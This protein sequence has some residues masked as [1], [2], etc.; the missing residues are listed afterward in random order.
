MSGFTPKT[1]RPSTRIPRG[2][3]SRLRRVRTS[4]P[5]PTSS[6]THSAI[7][8]AT[9]ILPVRDLP[10]SVFEVAADVFSASAG[11][12]ESATRSGARPKRSAA[13]A[14]MLRVKSEDGAVR[15]QARLDL[16]PGAQRLGCKA[17][18]E[19]RQSAAG[20]NQQQTLRQQL[21]KQLPASRAQ[22]Q[23]H[24]ELALPRRIPRHQQ[25]DHV[26]QSDQQNQPH[27]R[28]QHPQR[29]AVHF[30]IS[31][32]ALCVLQA[33]YGSLLAGLRI[34]QP[35]IR[36]RLKRGLQLRDRLGFGHTGRKASNQ[37][38]APPGGIGDVG[39]AILQ[40]I[41]PRIQL[42]PALQRNPEIGRTACFD[43]FKALCA[44]C[45]QW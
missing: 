39:F 18:K 25:H 26:A 8:S 4:S 13:S 31:G 22:R 32:K 41:A 29:L 35:D 34:A 19:P 1:T 30:V 28:H 45:P 11:P 24:R 27:H 21:P 42:R 14:R 36:R 20:R 23:P 5:P 6:T 37:P 3:F 2:V 12:A 10:A 43:A 17:G 38:Q 40:R 9:M 33:E 16:R 44:Q 15:R 7:C